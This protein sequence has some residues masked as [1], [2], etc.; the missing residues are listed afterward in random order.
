MWSLL[1]KNNDQVSEVI[2][3]D[4]LG[5]ICSENLSF[6]NSYLL[7]LKST[8]KALAISK[9]IVHIT[10]NGSDTFSEL[11]RHDYIYIKEISKTTIFFKSV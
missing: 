9:Y 4:Y 3:N 7:K 10:K 1:L 8:M 5:H 6:I 11:S 2:P